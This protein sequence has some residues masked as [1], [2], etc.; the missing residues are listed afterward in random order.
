MRVDS[1]SDV[2]FVDETDRDLLGSLGALKW[3]RPEVRSA[4]EL[5]AEADKR[6]MQKDYEGALKFYDRALR[7]QPNHAVMLLNR[8][9]ALIGLERNYEAYQTAEAA[10]E[11]GADR[12]KSLYRYAK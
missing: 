12:A 10:L 6:F 11:K 3:Y 5:R 8:S 9:S 4:E 7:I 1:P 2:I